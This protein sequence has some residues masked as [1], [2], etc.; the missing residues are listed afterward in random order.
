MI[1]CA[2]IGSA[3]AALRSGKAEFNAVSAVVG[4]TSGFIAFITLRG[5]KAVFMLEAA[6]EMPHFN[7]YSMAFSGLLVGL[8]SPKAYAL[9]NALVDDL[10]QRLSSAFARR[11]K[12][13]AR[14][15][16]EPPDV[17]KA[18]VAEHAGENGAAN[19][20]NFAG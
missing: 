3:V 2:F 8:F 16:V 20:G 15:G 6:G 14:P 5:G 17:I 7:P 9:L 19:T 11:E 10:Y 18:G 12:E 4:L 1:A 13:V